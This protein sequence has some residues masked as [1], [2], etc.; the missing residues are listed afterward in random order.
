MR[1]AFNNLFKNFNK[2]KLILN[3]FDNLIKNNLLIEGKI[4]KNFE[5]K[6]SKYIKSSYCV[7]TGNGTDALRNSS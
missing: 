1:I 2:N 3:K 6:F 5:N 4:V 7:S